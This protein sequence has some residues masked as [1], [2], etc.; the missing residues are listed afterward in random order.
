[1]VVTRPHNLVVSSDKVGDTISTTYQYAGHGTY[2]SEDE[3]AQ[4]QREAQQEEKKAQIDAKRPA[5]DLY[6]SELQLIHGKR[7]RVPQRRSLVI[8]QHILDQIPRSSLVVNMIPFYRALDGSDG[9]TTLQAVERLR[10]LYIGKYY[11]LQGDV[12]RIQADRDY[13]REGLY[14]FS[15]FGQVPFSQD[16][17]IPVNVDCTST[18]R[19]PPYGVAPILGK[20]T[21]FSMSKN[22]VGKTIIVPEVQVVAVAAPS[23][24]CGDPEEIIINQ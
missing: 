24:C 20:I 16:Y 10:A 4:E 17:Y 12:F 5:L 9:S 14:H 13:P 22:R 7:F 1:V 21:G 6:K 2:K 18:E 11:M 15:V 23:S 19:V 3:L 8:L